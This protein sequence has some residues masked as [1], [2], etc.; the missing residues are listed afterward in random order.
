MDL[1]KFNK[2]NLNKGS[3]KLK[4]FL[5]YFTNAI[6][7]STLFFPVYILKTLASGVLQSNAIYQRY[8]AKKIQDCI[9][10]IKL[11]EI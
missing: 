6:L 9:V 10:Q 2:V 7:F 4:V 8:P 5:W 11:S 3:N 1:N